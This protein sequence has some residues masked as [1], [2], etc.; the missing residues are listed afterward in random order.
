MT[1]DTD[2]G[3]ER[4]RPGAP[5]D[6]GDGTTDS[7]TA[8]DPSDG[9]TVTGGGDASN[10]DRA[11][12]D[13]PA[14]VWITSDLLAVLLERA[15]AAEPSAANVVLDATAAGDLRPAPDLPDDRP[16]FTH[17]YVPDAGRSVGAVFGVDLGRPA[18][19]GNARFVSHPQGPLAVTRRDD[20]AAV[21]IVAVPP[22]E[23]DHVAAFDRSGQRRRLHVVDAAPPV[24]RL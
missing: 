20:L 16:V 6:I 13:D 9:D 21:V 3:S 14:P 7:D 5:P 19:G 11:P 24:E 18:G 17:F 12:G 4:G 15:A 8:P 22:W 2:D 1:D 23:P 10:D